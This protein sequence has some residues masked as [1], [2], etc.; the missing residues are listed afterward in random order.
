MYTNP[1]PA[2]RIRVDPSNPGQFFACCGL[3]ELA[4]R[5]WDG[6]EGWFSSAEPIFLTHS[7][8]GKECDALTLVDELVR[9]GLAGELSPELREEREELEKKR[10]RL[11]KENKALPKHE[12]QRRKELGKMLRE[13]RIVIGEPFNLLLDWWRNDDEDIPKTWAGSQE[14]LRIAQAA[15]TLLRD[16]FGFKIPFEYSSVMRPVGDDA[17]G[18]EE[19]VE[20]FYFDARRGANALA[21]DIGFMPDSLS[22]TTV[23]YPAVE[24]LC[25]VGLQRFRPV[26]TDTRRLFDYFTWNVPLTARV[27]TS[28][29]AGLL[30]FVGSQGYRFQIAFRTGKKMHKAFTP[31]I[32]IERS[33]P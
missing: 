18:D 15:L 28:A 6:A 26:P 7:T 31:A 1:D 4:D 32:A 3:L 21:L 27:A 10:K 17:E 16:A 11:K 23:A 30:P 14:V 24:F 2:I 5:L 13:G 33:E 29:V 22:M 25:L 20:P 8:S 12:E 9:T 19:K